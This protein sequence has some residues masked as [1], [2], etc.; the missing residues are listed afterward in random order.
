MNFTGQI[1]TAAWAEAAYGV[2][3]VLENCEIEILVPAASAYN[4]ATGKNVPGTGAVH[5]SGRARV[6]ALL[7]PVRDRIDAYDRVAQN[8]QFQIAG[9]VTG[10]ND[11]MTVRVLACDLT[12]ELVGYTYNIIEAFN[13][14]GDFETTFKAVVNSAR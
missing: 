11:S 4:A 6:Q 5:W 7:V 12:E 1:R 9:N 13:S 3:S 10:I 2:W 8:Y 14:D